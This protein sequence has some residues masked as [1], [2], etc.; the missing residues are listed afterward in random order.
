MV[1]Y[2]VFSW[3]SHQFHYISVSLKWHRT[4]IP[5]TGGYPARVSTINQAHLCHMSRQYLRPTYPGDRI[6]HLHQLYD[7]YLREGNRIFQSQ[8]S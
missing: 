1:V 7:D 3:N 4:N 6:L 2:E 5:I 8:S